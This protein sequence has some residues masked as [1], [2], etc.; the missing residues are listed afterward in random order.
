MAVA[1][2]AML[3]VRP[4]GGAESLRSRNKAGNQGCSLGPWLVAWAGMRPGDV[5]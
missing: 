3:L 1:F 2:V 4:Q 5:V